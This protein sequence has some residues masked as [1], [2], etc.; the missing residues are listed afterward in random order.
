M[1][2][3]EDSLNNYEQFEAE[4]VEKTAGLGFVEKAELKN[5]IRDDHYDNRYEFRRD[6]C[7][8]QPLPKR[9][10]GL[11]FPP[12]IGFASAFILAIV[13]N[14]NPML[15][16]VLNLIF[17]VFLVFLTDTVPG[18]DIAE[19][20]R[21]YENYASFMDSFKQAMAVSP[22]TATFSCE[23]SARVCSECGW[24]N[25]AQNAYCHDC[26]SQLETDNQ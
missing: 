3:E 8:Y 13:F 9:L 17:V 25:P 18:L 7:R 2:T 24:Q 12:F 5:K 19:Q 23:E 26:G 16:G 14:Q 10:F 1:G 21:I 15:Y 20:L 11:L 22:E 6:E 4:V